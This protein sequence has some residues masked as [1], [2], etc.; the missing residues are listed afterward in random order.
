[1]IFNKN[2]SAI[3]LDPNDFTPKERKL[4]ESHN[5]KLPLLSFTEIPGG[6]RFSKEDKEIIDLNLKIMRLG[7]LDGILWSTE[8]RKEFFNNLESELNP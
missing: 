6:Y 2:T 1:M 8:E 3:I 7:Y 5:K 4:L